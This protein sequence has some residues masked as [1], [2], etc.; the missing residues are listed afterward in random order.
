MLMAEDVGLVEQAVEAKRQS[1]DE[2]EP[3]SPVEVEAP[4]PSPERVSDADP[5]GQRPDDAVLALRKPLRRRDEDHLASVATQPCLVCGR[6]PCD[7][8]HLRFAQPP[9]LG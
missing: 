4:E 1:L 3:L 6:Q 5:A 9:A 7:A 8:H 2:A